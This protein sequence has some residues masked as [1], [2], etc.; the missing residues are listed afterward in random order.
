MLVIK[1]RLRVFGI[2]HNGVGQGQTF[3]KGTKTVGRT[4][5]YTIEVI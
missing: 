2:V 3:P 1:P 4:V 5:G